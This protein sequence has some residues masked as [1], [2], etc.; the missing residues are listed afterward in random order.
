MKT[1]ETWDL[2][3]RVFHWLLVA[4]IANAYLTYAFGDVNMTWHMWN[5]Y[6]ILTLCLYRILWGIFGS[7]TARFTNFIKGPKGVLDYLKSVKSPHP[8]KHLGH[9]PLG[10]LMILALLALMLVQGSMGLFTSDEILVEG[11]L[12]YLVSSD[13]SSLAG[14]LHRQGYWIILGF[15]GL[16][17]AAAFFYLFVKKENLISAMVT[18]RKDRSLVPDH[19]ALEKTPA[20]FAVVLLALSAAI[21]WL[22]V[23]IW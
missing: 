2:P 19:A 20:F 14:T 13:W 21:V 17:V 16:H 15:V 7:S 8:Q 5:G 1:V 18:G 9:N 6:A 3:T 22:G 4:L 23:N 12:V 11:P 10:G